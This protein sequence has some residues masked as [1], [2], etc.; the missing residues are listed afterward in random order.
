MVAPVLLAQGRVEYFGITTQGLPNLGQ[1]P[2]ELAKKAVAMLV[3]HYFGLAKSLAEVR[4]WCDAHEISLIEDCA[5]SFFGEAGER[6]IGA[7]GDFSCASLTKFFPVPEGGL[8]ASNSRQL[9]SVELQPQTLGKQV[10]GGLDVLHVS[11]QHQRLFGLNTLIE[12]FFKIKNSV[13]RQSN[14]TLNQESHQNQI[15]WLTVI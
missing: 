5:H 4:K 11:T 6:Q 15:S 7:W 1:I 10:K 12:A 8:L 2:L 14:M 13:K 3:P 9:H